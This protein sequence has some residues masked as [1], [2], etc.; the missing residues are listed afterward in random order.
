MRIQISDSDRFY[1]VADI[2]IKT[3]GFLRPSENGF[4]PCS[5]C[6]RLISMEGSE[7]DFMGFLVFWGGGAF[8]VFVIGFVGCL[9]TI[10]LY[11][12]G[13]GGSSVVGAACI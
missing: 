1:S 13:A 10:Y 12:L 6:G 5:V 4:R 9:T 8:L 11:A 2:D 3:H 7:T